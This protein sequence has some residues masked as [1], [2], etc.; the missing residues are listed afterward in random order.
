QGALR[1]RRRDE[2]LGGERRQPVAE[3]RELRREVVDP[4][5]LLAP[6]PCP[7]SPAQSS[8]RLEVLLKEGDPVPGFPVGWTVGQFIGRS[9]GADG[10]WAA[11]LTAR[12]AGYRIVVVGQRP[13]ELDGPVELLRGETPPAA[14]PNDFMVGAR[15]AGGRLA[16]GLARHTYL[17]PVNSIWIDDAPI[18]RVGDPIADRPGAS[19]NRLFGTVGFAEDG[20]ALVSGL[21][22]DT[23]QVGGLK[24]MLWSWPE[25]EALFTRG[26]PVPGLPS[27]TVN[28]GDPVCSP[29]ARQWLVQFVIQDGSREGLLRNGELLE[30]APGAFALEGDA[31][32]P[33]FVD[34]HVGLTWEGFESAR[35]NDRGHVAF[36]GRT[37]LDGEA[38]H[39]LVRNRRPYSFQA[40]EPLLADLDERSGVVITAGHTSVR[41][42]D[43]E[44]LGANPAVDVDRD[45]VPDPEYTAP[46]VSEIGT[47]L[48]RDDHETVMFRPVY[49][50]A[51]E[52]YLG[53]TRARHAR[54]DTS[55]C[56]AFPNSTER[57]AELVATGS[58]VAA[59]NEV[60]LHAIGLPTDSRGYTLFARDFGIVVGPGG[61]QGQLCL[62]GGIGRLQSQL[63]LAGT[64]GR[65][66]IPLDLT[67]IPRP[68]GAT[69]ALAGDTWYAQAWFRDM[70]QGTPTSNFS[71]ALRLDLE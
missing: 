27:V 41:Y 14:H 59:D 66:T 70:D 51:G 53:M 25:Q 23:P 60:T 38:R 26:D 43:A 39:V 9:I 19:W 15:L 22:Q 64:D 31:I 21:I 36:V 45:G 61:S 10:G 44:V 37:R 17:N 68:T 1:E 7:T 35:I 67:Q 71:S 18:V 30:Y 13:G 16:Y 2:H 55:V 57:P 4:L 56:N 49:D 8:D 47:F 33:V 40:P 69:A 48:M 20:R 3:R 6:S 65:A 12:T 29:D 54:V 32:P 34:G 62:A 63:F 46:F 50:T 52:P 24:W 11:T 28:I 42:E 5:A 58:A